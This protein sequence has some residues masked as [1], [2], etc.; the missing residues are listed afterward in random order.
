LIAV[1]WLLRYGLTTSGGGMAA[2]A[3]VCFFACGIMLAAPWWLA[4]S[5]LWVAIVTETASNH[6]QL[7]APPSGNFFDWMGEAAYAAMAVAAGMIPGWVAWRL[8][9]AEP[10]VQL[11]AAV[12]IGLAGVGFA[13]LSALEEGSPL[14]VISGR[15]AASLVRRPLPWLL[16]TMAAAALAAVTASVGPWMLERGGVLTAPVAFA[17][18]LVYARSVGKLGRRLSQA[19]SADEAE[20]PD[21]DDGP[22]E[23]GVP[24][25]AGSK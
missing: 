9:A 12:A 22:S 10:A 18:S 4:A 7:Y 5:A 25:S 3:Q 19:T 16:F 2:I 14:S 20:E 21:E 1:A 8:L 15:L 11:P 17:A 13:L 24:S 6:D 23:R